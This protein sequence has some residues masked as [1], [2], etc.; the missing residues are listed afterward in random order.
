MGGDDITRNG[1]DWTRDLVTFNCGGFVLVFR[2]NQDVVT[3]SIDK[4][5]GI[6]TKTSEV[7]VKDVKESEIKKVRE[8]LDRICWLLSFAGLS[9]VICY[10]Y[11][12]PNSSGLAHFSSVVG[13]ANYFRPSINIRDGITVKNFVEQAYDTYFRLEKIRKL[14]V[15][16]DYL[17]QA[18][19]LEQPTEL[20]LIL[21]FVA[22]E[23]LKDTYARSKSIPYVKGYYRKPPTH[24][25]K[26]GAKYSFEDLL[27]LMLRDVRMRKGLKRVIQLR[28]EIIHSGLSRKPHSRQFAMYERIHDLI[29]EYVI[30]LLG[31]HGHYLIYASA[32]DLVA[33]V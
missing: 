6:F 3:G 18:E 5:K 23:N 30:R 22:L 11:E 31:Y 2:Q 29:R 14:N 1:T 15:V 10:G 9:R 12:Y 7:I 33:Q 27:E 24:V 17:V 25:G 20:K 21:A 13:T 26:P 19:R 32:G 8:T 4:F 16:I 28:N